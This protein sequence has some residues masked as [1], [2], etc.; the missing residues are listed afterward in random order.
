MQLAI[1]LNP[2]PGKL[3]KMSFPTLLPLDD[4]DDDVM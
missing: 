3:G 4:D 2:L 1:L